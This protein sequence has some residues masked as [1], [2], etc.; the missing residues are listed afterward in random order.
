MFFYLSK[1][2]WFLVAPSNLLLVC[3]GLA[4]AALMLRRRRLSAALAIIGAAG[5]G[6]MGFLPLHVWLLAPLENRFPLPD[7]A[8]KQIDGIIVLG[9]AVDPRTTRARGVVQL[10]DSA[11]RM[12]VALALARRFPRATFVF[13]GGS[14][15]LLGG[16]ATEAEAAKTFYLSLGLQAERLVL[17]DK[18]RNTYENAVYTKRLVQS[19]QGENWLLVT[20]AFH[21]PRSVGIFRKVG[22]PVIAY[23]ADFRTV[24]RASEYWK[25]RREIS[26][27]LR[28]T[29]IAVREWIGLAAYY[30]TGRTD[31]LLP[32]PD[33][34]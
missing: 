5:Y 1:I 6:V 28:L 32:G 33:N 31:A 15:S 16:A 20:S 19:K 23:P 12:T 29:D 8:G 13:T 2:L 24:G 25:P 11:T 14:A 30:L 21:M 27:G 9:G 7:L 17:E 22:F 26:K 4:G 3:F 18:S 34:G 10:S